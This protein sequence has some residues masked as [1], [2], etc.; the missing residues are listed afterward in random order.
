MSNYARG[1]Y[2]QTKTRSPV[3]LG[4]AIAVNGAVIGAL[5]FA[6]PEVRKT[7]PTYIDAINIPIEPPP[8][9]VI[10]PPKQP[11][12]KLQRA[13]PQQIPTSSPIPVPTDTDWL[14]RIPLPPG[15]GTGDLGGP[16]TP[17][18]PPH[19]PVLVGPQVNPR[20]ANALQPPYPPGMIRAEK[21]GKVVV[22]VRIG[23]DGR[24]KEVQKVEAADDAFYRAT[25]EQAMRRWRFL[26]ATSD[27]A[28]VEGWRVMSVVF[29]LDSL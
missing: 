4:A 24:V 2:A 29:R 23:A 28:P 8:P 21:E 12:Q 16:I 27:G 1:A 15:P 3:S 11:E 19:T 7:L 14:P 5:L 18:V 26:P 20:Y 22:R 9:E 6:S 25:V 13:M 10:E 17:P